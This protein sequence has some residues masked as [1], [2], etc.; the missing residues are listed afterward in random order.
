MQVMWYLHLST[1]DNWYYHQRLGGPA[2]QPISLAAGLRASSLLPRSGSHFL[3]SCPPA[4]L[5]QFA[6]Y[7][8]TPV[9]LVFSVHAQN[10]MKQW[11]TSAVGY[12]I[13]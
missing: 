5:A 8:Y 10:R 1:H 4:L 3:L 9:Y 13:L 6:V 12:G 7:Q 2:R 11:L